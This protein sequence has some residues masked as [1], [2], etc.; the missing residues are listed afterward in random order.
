MKNKLLPED[1]EKLFREETGNDPICPGIDIYRVN[2]IDWLKTNICK[3]W[4]TRQPEQLE[5][6]KPIERQ[7]AW[8][9]NSPD[10]RCSCGYKIL[11]NF[12]YCPGCG[13]QIDREG[14]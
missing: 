7:T 14:E 1:I 2:F 5:K 12:N 4:N 6:V 11:P 13:K 8:V 10:L 3:A 9:D